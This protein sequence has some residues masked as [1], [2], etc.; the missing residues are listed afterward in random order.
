METNIY[1]INKHKKKSWK[2][3]INK[4]IVKIVKI[5]NLNFKIFEDFLANQIRFLK[6]R[7]L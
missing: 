3:K 4:S 2:K 5:I 6:L 1:K 7:M